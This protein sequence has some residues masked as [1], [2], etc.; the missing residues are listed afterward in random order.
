MK[1]V[2]AV[3]RSAKETTMDCMDTESWREPA[4]P[5]T[6]GADERRAFW[7]SI[8]ATLLTI[9]AASGII[10]MLNWTDVR[11]LGVDETAA[12]ARTD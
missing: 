11:S 7:A 4:A 6:I 3:F 12:V 10:L 2:S 8:I 5:P 1:P 9:A